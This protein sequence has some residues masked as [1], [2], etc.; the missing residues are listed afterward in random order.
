MPG[1]LKTH[2]LETAGLE[3]ASSLSPI[4]TRVIHRRPRAWFFSN[5][6]NRCFCEADALG[7]PP[8]PLFQPPATPASHRLVPGVSDFRRYGVGFP[9]ITARWW[10]LSWHTN[11]AK[12]PNSAPGWMPSSAGSAARGETITGP[13][14]SNWKNNLACVVASKARGGVFGGR[15]DRTMQERAVGADKT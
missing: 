15:V 6:P 8:R 4:Q 13:Q 9:S 11:R 1:A 14:M 10:A 2:R 5:A 3:I 12:M 7:L